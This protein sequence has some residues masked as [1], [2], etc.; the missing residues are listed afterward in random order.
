VVATGIDT[1]VAQRPPVAAAE[2]RIAEVAQRLRA[3]ETPRVAESVERTEAVKP[4]AAAVAPASVNDSIESAKAAIV[5]AIMPSRTGEEVT[6]R[7]LA[8]KPSLF[9][10]PASEGPEMRGPKAFIPPQPERLPPRTPRMPRVDELPVPAQNEI[11][12]RRGQLAP[13]E[14]PE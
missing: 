6:I 12:A 13:Q 5:A 3:S 9:I 10:D 2:S 14:H 1:A 11:R 4:A 7:P 8:P